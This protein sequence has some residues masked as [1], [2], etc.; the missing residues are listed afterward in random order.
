M[1]HLFTYSILSA[2]TLT[3]FYCLLPLMPV[4]A[5][6]FKQSRRI[7]MTGYATSIILPLLLIAI[8]HLPSLYTAELN[9]SHDISIGT[10]TVHTVTKTMPESHW[11][12]PA[13]LLYANAIATAGIL[14][15]TII[16]VIRITALR[17]RATLCRIGGIRTII[18]ND[19]AITPFSWCNNIFLRTTDI[20]DSHNAMIIDH[21]HAHIIHHHWIDILTGNIVAALQWYNPLSWKMLHRLRDI[22][23]YQADAYVISKGTDAYEYQ[24]FLIKQTAGVRFAS[25]ANSLNH[26]SLNKRITMMLSNKNRRTSRF[27]IASAATIGAIAIGALSF[28]GIAQV[29]N[30]MSSEATENRTTSTDKVKDFFLTVQK[31][32]ATSAQT[33]V[34]V[35]SDQTKEPAR[36]PET[37]PQFPG[38]DAAMW[39]FLYEN[40]KY[41]ASAIEAKEQGKVNVIFMVDTDGKVCDATISRGVSPAIDKEALRVVSLMPAFI[42]GQK[43]GKPVKVAFSIEITFR[44]DK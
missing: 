33:N 17:F 24:M 26:S 13:S 8:P 3:I 37:K 28:S 30:D 18:H 6:P 32:S 38:G 14:L 35:Q 22:H 2:I 36:E 39:K 40:L 11:H 21:E 42:P 44:L 27:R 31:G 25:L 43:D 16:T 9:Y 34:Q 1:E 15:F 5:T 7:I 23:E 29:I 10:P 20:T 4:S 12:I 19:N 41:P